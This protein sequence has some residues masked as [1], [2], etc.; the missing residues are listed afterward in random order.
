M[1]SLESIKRQNEKTKKQE[2]LQLHRQTKTPGQIPQTIQVDS[3][4][5]LPQNFQ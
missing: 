2:V 1:L 5:I 3:S 4:K